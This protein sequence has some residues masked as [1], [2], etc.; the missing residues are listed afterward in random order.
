MDSGRDEEGEG[1]GN[2]NERQKER[3]GGRE[4]RSKQAEN[5]CRTPFEAKPRTKG[6]TVMSS[7]S[8]G[9]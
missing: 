4:G 6:E 9:I 3:K 7:D 1:K 5:L 8:F 2:E